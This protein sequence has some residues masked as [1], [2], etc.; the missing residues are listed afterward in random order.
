MFS[1]TTFC[2]DGAVVV[3]VVEGLRSRTTRR[4]RPSTA[5]AC[6]RCRRG[7]RGS[8]CRRRRPDHALG[9]PAH[10]VAAVLVRSGSVRPPKLDV[11]G[12][13]GPR[14][15]P[16]VAVAQP[17]VGHL[18]LPAVADLL[19]E[20]AELVADAVADRRDLERRERVH[21]AG[22]EPAEAAVAEARLL[23]LPSRS[24]RGRARARPSPAAPPPSMPRL[25]RL[26]PSCGPEQELG[27]QVADRAARLAVVG[28]AGLDPARSTSRRTASA[29]ARYQSLRVAAPGSGRAS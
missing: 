17:L 15:L 3:A 6:W 20:D 18:D 4:P 1:E 5:A 11:E 29:S 10:A 12:D 13:L 9:H 23:L 25:S 26:L 21:V 19:V 22:G 7:S 2:V 27:R 16:R 14:D 8:A 24:G 28:L